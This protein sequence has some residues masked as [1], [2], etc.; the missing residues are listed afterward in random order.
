M[1]QSEFAFHGTVVFELRLIVLGSSLQRL[2]RVKY[3]YTPD[4]PYVS[5]PNVKVTGSLQ[6]KTELEFLVPVRKRQVDPDDD[7]PEQDIW[8]PSSELMLLGILH[9]RNFPRL[10]ELIDQPWRSSR[11]ARPRLRPLK[12]YARLA[13]AISNSC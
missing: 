10:E 6:L 13:N 4:W 9:V 12:I 1:I 7:S 3:G 11:N 5:M 2:L 8:K